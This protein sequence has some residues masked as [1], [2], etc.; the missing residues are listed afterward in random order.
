MPAS[1]VAYVRSIRV[2]PDRERD[3]FHPTPPEGTAALLAVERFP[4]VVW[5]PACGAGDMSRV[6]EASDEITR[7]ISTDLIDRGFGRTGV[8]FLRDHETSADHVVTNPP[9]RLASQFAL[10]AR[11]RVRGKVALLGRLAWLEGVGRRRMFEQTG[12]TRVWVF[13]RRLRVQRG[14]LP[15][16][17]DRGGM[18]AFA[19]FVW[20]PGHDGPWQGGFID[21][22]VEGCS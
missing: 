10:H 3:D 9:F 22:Q 5:E 2:S 6:L 21:P 11:A 18:I 17:G 1:S 16:P 13:S 12:L 7:V 15:E 19:W 20:D 8:D 14:R 4:G